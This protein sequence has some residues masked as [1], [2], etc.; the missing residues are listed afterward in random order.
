MSKPKAKAKALVK[1]KPKATPA[2]TKVAAWVPDCGCYG[3]GRC[4][5]NPKGCD[6]CWKDSAAGG[7]N[8]FRLKKPTC[9]CKRK[10]HLL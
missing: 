9:S 2:T 6:Q 8:I 10:T 4:R 1:A 7:F 5:G 3:C